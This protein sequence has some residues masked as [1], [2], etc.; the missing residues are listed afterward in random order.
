MS[1]VP[2]RRL[3]APAPASRA[4]RRPGAAPRRW[5]GFTLVEV[6]VALALMA[7]MSTL[8]WQGLDGMLRA[9]E[10]SALVLDR[11]L[12]LNT[13]MAQ[14]EQDLRAVQE[15]LAV[16]ALSF[17]G[18]TLRLTRRAEGGV[19]LVAWAVRGGRWQRWTSPVYTEAGA[20]Q[21]GWL[22]SQQLLGNED[23]Q[24][25]LAEGVAGW[26]IFFY[27]GNAWT[28]AQSTGDLADVAPPPP[29][30]PPPTGGSGGVPPPG[31]G[32]PARE[33]LPDGLRLVIMLEG[34]GLTRD[35]VL[36]PGG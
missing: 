29:A 34:G 24:L 11:T 25:T 16:P 13:V 2:L 18:Q 7:L 21:D 22:R 5:R 20:L 32:G 17:D 9:R 14:W 6:L 8:A 19:V 31:G 1:A 10:G 27:R 35:L 30:A 28:N 36:E 3:P 33:R 4:R 12:R 15:T 23:T 26:Q